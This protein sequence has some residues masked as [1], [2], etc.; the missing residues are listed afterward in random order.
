MGD[1]TRDLQA[2]L[3]DAESVLDALRDAQVD[4]VVGRRGVLMLRLQEMERRLRASEQ[5]FTALAEQIDDVFWFV[6]FAPPA[7]T[8]VSPAF[9]TIWGLPSDRLYADHALW[10]KCAHDDD[11][12]R[13]AEA[14]DAF[15][16]ERGGYDLE[17]RIV[18]PDGSLRWIHEKAVAVRDSDGRPVGACGISRDITER[19]ESE[20]A[21]RRHNELLA[22]EAEARR[23]AESELRR[24]NES[25]EQQVDRRTAEL[26]RQAAHL[27]A[28]ASRLSRVEHRERKRLAQILHDNIQQLIVG[29][30][31][32]IGRLKRAGDPAKVQSI[33][34]DAESILGEALRASRDL[35]IDLSPP[36][37]H[38][39]GLTG[40][41]H[42]LA[43]RMR[44]KNLFTVNLR[45]DAAAEP[46]V[47]ETR[48]LLFECVR[49]LLFN[50]V[51]HAG[52]EEAD[53]TLVR[54]DDGRIAVTVADRGRGFDPERVARR[55]AEEATFGLFSI[56]ERLAHIGGRM[57]IV[58]APGRGTTVM[59][60]A[61]MGQAPQAAG[62]PAA[63][64]GAEADGGTIGGRPKGACCGVLIVD[65][66]RIMREGLAGL[67]QF[68][69]DI[70][71]VG[72]AA[73]GAQAVELAARLRPDVIIMDVNL[74]EMNGIEAT[75]QI[76]AG[77]P[78]VKVIGLS[79]RTEPDVIAAMKEAGAAAYLTKG[80][81][82]GDLIA[83]IRACYT[84]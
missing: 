41:L 10:L 30:A 84:H 75:R 82:S 14:I 69:P 15:K 2:R 13:V 4:A 72:E 3:D 60:A 71:V 38:E 56:Q 46:A 81:P 78:E 36:A 37:L 34:E 54:G 51:K 22:E 66:H 83:A 45:C 18:R 29:A 35:T 33:A 77:R 16:K 21:V 44:D 62:R 7:V 32:Q 19:R 23:R 58:T 5:R 8:Y 17:F 65:D 57:E 79:M 49:E 40:G 52:V 28:L 80:G 25:L 64:G 61:P 9:E 70:E 11:R 67:L 68:E 47:E 74:G 26:R 39:T 12:A 20:Q 42:W 6:Q 55:G 76:V 50:A 73:D 27:R 31:M 48:L 59:L 43:A 53:V 63:A 1:D 24:L